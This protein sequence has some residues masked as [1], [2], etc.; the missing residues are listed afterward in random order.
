MIW[1]G[2]GGT[3][4]TL[5][6]DRIQTHRHGKRRKLPF[7]MTRRYGV[8]RLTCTFLVAMVTAWAQDMRRVA[9][10]DLAREL[11]NRTIRVE[12]PNGSELEGKLDGTSGQALQL[13]QRN[14]VRAVDRGEIVR[15]YVK[16]RPQSGRATGTAI[17]VGLSVPGVALSDR[18][19]AA[20]MG[21]GMLGAIGYGLGA[22]AD[23]TYWVEVRLLP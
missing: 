21:M 16:W 5:F 19:G 9:W 20:V 23:R 14:T 2:A 6:P 15:L 11:E 4:T 17:G 18:R 1:C 8:V 13:R 12:M 7:R 3:I 10:A 22:L